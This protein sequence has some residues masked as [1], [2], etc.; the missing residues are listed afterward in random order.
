M[1]GTEHPDTLAAFGAAVHW[2]EVQLDKVDALLRQGEDARALEQ[3]G[4]VGRA[5]GP[6]LPRRWLEAQLERLDPRQRPLAWGGLTE[7]LASGLLITRRGH[8]VE[9]VEHAITLFNAAL[10]DAPGAAPET[11][12]EAERGLG[13]AYGI[14]VPGDRGENLRRSLEHNQAAL[15][16][17][18]AAED[19]ATWARVQHELG[20]AWKR[21]PSGDRAVNR[22]H[23]VTALEAA[24]S[25]SPAHLDPE[26]RLDIG[27][28]LASVYFHAGDLD[29]AIE[30]AE[31]VEAQT[32]DDAHP[33][34]RAGRRGNLA[35]YRVSRDREGDVPAAINDLTAALSVLTELAWPDG[36][37]PEGIEAGYAERDWATL[38]FQ[39]GRA[40]VRRR[41]GDREAHAE[42]AVRAWRA[43]LEVFTP[44]RFPS[45]CRATASMLA[46]VLGD[47]KRWPEAYEVL[48]TAIRASD[49]EYLSAVTDQT[50]E[51][52]AAVIAGIYRHMVDACLHLDP[53]RRAEA[54]IRAE[55][56]RSRLLRDQ[57][58]ALEIPPPPGH[59]A[60]RRFERERDL[61]ARLRELQQRQEESPPEERRLLVDEQGTLRQELLELWDEFQ[62]D[63]QTA[64]YVALRRGEQ[65]DWPGLCRWL[66]G[67]GPRV[68]LLEYF[69]L[70]D[71]LVA[72]LAQPGQAE[73]GGVPD[74]APA[75]RRRPAAPAVRAGGAPL[76]PRVAT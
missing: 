32:G 64:G 12:L 41:E 69:A 35:Q 10:A 24:W 52:T 42:Q 49:A 46:R 66:E 38:Q 62:T 15:G 74:S 8:R 55:E 43:A 70:E 28:D 17:C 67:Q 40:W 2:T 51:T 76:R 11:L 18:S 72:F 36:T 58:A 63:G 47:H 39:L 31:A 30:V 1:L 3:F 53:P 56:G 26:A 44:E 14:R 22:T 59:E 29:R 5:A 54:L 16:R 48:L 61:L 68:A 65:L 20:L 71:G 21:L 6:D 57:L 37:P 7:R 75:G 50:K 19:P 13:Y 23:A 60:D 4:A 45:A 25:V 34:R 9:N 27:T 33:R 73:P